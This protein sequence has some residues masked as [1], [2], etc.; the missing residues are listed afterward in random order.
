MNA[1]P[2]FDGKKLTQEDIVIECRK[3]DDR[4]EV[5]DAGTRAWL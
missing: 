3:A 1:A 2:L 4:P 5:Y